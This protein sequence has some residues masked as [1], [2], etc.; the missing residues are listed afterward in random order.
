MQSAGAAM[1][2]IVA[3]VRRVTTIMGEIAAASKEQSAGVEQVNVAIVQIDN[4][5]QQNAAL[6]EEATAAARSMEE[7]SQAL[8]NSVAVFKLAEDRGGQRREERPH[9]AGKGAANGKALH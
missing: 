8:V 1:D 3:Q 7:Q 2:E 4:I 9:H 5:T 6:V